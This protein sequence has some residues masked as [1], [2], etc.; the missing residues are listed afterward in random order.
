M[1]PAR[2]DLARCRQDEVIAAVEA[3][4]GAL[5]GERPLLAAAGAYLQFYL[6]RLVPLMRD[7]E[8]W[9]VPLIRQYLPPEV[10]HPGSI[11]REHETIELLTSA[12]AEGVG[13]GAGNAEVEAELATAVSD[14]CLLLRDHI[15]RE[16]EVVEPLLERLA[17]QRPER[18]SS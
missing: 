17:A 4:E 18:A 10:M 16:A 5:R 14:L 2:F 1:D 7:E 13:R 11:R 9:L 12:I 3:L 6:T 15:R 8:A